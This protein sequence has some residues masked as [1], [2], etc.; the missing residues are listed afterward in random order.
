MQVIVQLPGQK[1]GHKI[2][3]R[4]TAL[5]Y[6]KTAQLGLGLRFEYRLH[7]TD[8]DSRR[9]ALPD[10]GSLIV[11]FVEVPDDLDKCFPESLLVRT[12]LGGILTIDKAEDLFSVVVI[13]GDRDFDIL[14]LQVY[15]RYRSSSSFV[16]RCS[17][18]SSPF[19]ETYFLPLK[20]MIS[21]ALR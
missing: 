15:D 9:N 12:A 17:R 14:P 8:T 2:L 16:R 18:S 7:D 20:L 4:R 11:F 19:F 21:P 3:H 6:S 10:I 1:I 13:M 5:R